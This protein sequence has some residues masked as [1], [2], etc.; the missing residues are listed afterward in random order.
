MRI[1]QVEAVPLLA[2]L[3]TPQR[4]AQDYKVDVA[5]VLVRIETDDGIVGW[6]ETLGRWTPKSYAT[7]VDDLLAPRLVGRDPF[8]AGA[9]W[10]DMAGALSGRGG[11]MLVEAIAGVDIALWDVMGRALDQPI[12]RLLAGAGRQRLPAYASSIMVLPLDDTVRAAEELAGSRFRAVKLKV[13]ASPA[14]E[15]ERIRRVREV[16]GPDRE[17]FLD[18]NWGYT[19]A[20]ATE[21]ARRAAEYDVGWWEEPLH[22]NDHDGYQLLAKQSVL[23]LA[24]GESEYTAKG[25]RDLIASRTLSVVQPD[26]ARAGGISESHR[27]AQLA[28]VFDVQFAP[29]IGFSGGICVAATIQLAAASR[30]FRA[31]EL[32]TLPNPLREEILVEPVGEQAQL[33]EDGMLAVPTTPGIGAEVDL[34]A[35]ERYR[36]RV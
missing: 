27:I 34:R 30:T 18:G 3:P 35:V 20:T 36:I 28:E 5:M 13:A 17:L 33:D 6:G 12:H 19:L 14:F 11:G 15:A 25:L 7:I 8:D 1:K 4:T 31:F 29:H 26:I 23:P 24:A 16:L 32:M 10:D 21:M 22:P 9:I 2:R